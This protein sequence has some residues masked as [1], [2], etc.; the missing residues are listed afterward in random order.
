M[1][2]LL[3]AP[4]ISPRRQRLIEEMGL[5]RFSHEK[6]PTTIAERLGPRGFPLQRLS[7]PSRR[8]KIFTRP[9][10]Q[11]SACECLLMARS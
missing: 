3:P 10:L 6:R 4:V 5:R 7:S 2:D 1:Q 8:R 11:L 9:D